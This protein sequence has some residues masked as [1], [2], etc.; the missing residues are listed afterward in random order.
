[1]ERSALSNELSKM[2]RDGLLTVEGRQFV[3]KV[4]EENLL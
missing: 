4:Q 3:L 1:M 2:Q